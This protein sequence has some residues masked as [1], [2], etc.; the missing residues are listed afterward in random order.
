MNDLQQDRIIERLLR[1]IHTIGQ[2]D[3]GWDGSL[4]TEAHVR[5]LLLDTMMQAVLT[6]RATTSS[7]SS[8]PTSSRS[9]SPTSSHPTLPTTT[10]V[11]SSSCPMLLLPPLPQEPWVYIMKRHVNLGLTPD[12]V[13][14]M[15][16]YE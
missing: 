14:F 2:I 7:R 16:Q 1:H 12:N 6:P 15:I 8:T 5:R 11:V 4:W 9:S 13:Y 3:H 10:M